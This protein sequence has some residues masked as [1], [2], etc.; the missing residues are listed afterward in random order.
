MAS[1]CATVPTDPAARAA[2]EEA[3]DPLEPLNRGTFAFNRVLDGLLIKNIALL[4][5]TALPD[6]MRTAIRHVLH[7]LNQPVVFANNM[8]Q[9]KLDRAGTT[10]VRFSINTTIGI[11]GVFD[12][13]TDWG[14]AEQTGD[15][16]QT[17]WSWGVSDG[18]YL[19]LPLLGPSDPRDAIGEGVD[20]YID[21]FRYIARSEHIADM[22]K[23][24]FITD[25]V[26]QRAESI[27]DLDEVEK[28]SIDFYAQ[29]RS[30]WRQHRAQ[31]LAGTHSD[32]LVSPALQNNLYE[33]PAKSGKPTSTTP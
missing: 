29:L 5:R 2:F 21:P 4:Y 16:G 14:Y 30:L 15:F 20:G 24:R 6:Q 10:A 33:D 8:L 32:S 9:G 11:G 7:N 18:P 27:S 17:L 3:N 19:V 28:T 23:V 31:E 12:V 26:D 22:N 1:G 25:G 13:A